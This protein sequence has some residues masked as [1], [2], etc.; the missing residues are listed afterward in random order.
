MINDISGQS[1][2]VAR[3]NLSESRSLTSRHQNFLKSVRR[4]SVIWEFIFDDK[5]EER[6]TSRRTILPVQVNDVIKRRLVP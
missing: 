3:K 1:C 4:S 6:K 5:D 2:N